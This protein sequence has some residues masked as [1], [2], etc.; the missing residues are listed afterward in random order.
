MK[1]K[2]SGLLE[3]MDRK[4]KRIG[5]PEEVQAIIF[6]HVMI[7]DRKISEVENEL[8]EASDEMRMLRVARRGV[9]ILRERAS[10]ALEVKSGT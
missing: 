2:R 5:A 3:T 6:E 4:Q 8:H 10:E 7:L 1:E 9:R